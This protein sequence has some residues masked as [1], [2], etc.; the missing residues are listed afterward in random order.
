MVFERES[1]PPEGHCRSPSHPDLRYWK[2]PSQQSLLGLEEKRKAFLKRAISP[3]GSWALLPGRAC[4]TDVGG[5]ARATQC[6][7][8]L[9]AMEFTLRLL[10]AAEGLSPTAAL[11]PQSVPRLHMVL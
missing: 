2:R 5:K 7:L 8:L 3:K 11:H 6:E 1:T 10:A 4:G 9:P